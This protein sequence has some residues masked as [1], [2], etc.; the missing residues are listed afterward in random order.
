MDLGKV[1]IEK[2]AGGFGFTEGPVVYADG[3]VAFSD[4]A[5]GSI[6]RW[7]PST[8]DVEIVAD[9]I[10]LLDGLALDD[11]ERL[12]VCEGRDRRLTRIE[13]DGTVTVLADSFEG[14]RL[15]GPNDVVVGPD[16]AV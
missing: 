9:G 13:P 1:T 5:G 11:A 14:K 4:I 15:N 7:R 16:G 12:I 6:R 3:S 2:V 10:P 8:G